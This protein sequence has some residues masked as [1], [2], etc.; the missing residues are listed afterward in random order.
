MHFTVM[1]RQTGCT[2][3]TTI[4]VLLCVISKLNK[5]EL[6]A[7][8]NQRVIGCLSLHYKPHYTVMRRY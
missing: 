4:G 6:P 7:A 2:E 8:R 5:Q 1:A 3:S